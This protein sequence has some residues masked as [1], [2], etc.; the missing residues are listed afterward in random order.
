MN[1][2]GAATQRPWLLLLALVATL[3][4]PM[5]ASVFVSMPIDAPRSAVWRAVTDAR[6]LSR[7]QADTATGGLEQGNFVLGWPSLGAH[8]ALDVVRAVP[9]ESIVLRGGGATVEIALKDGAVELEHRGLGPNEDLEGLRAS[10]SVALG[11]LSHYLRHH[12]GSDRHVSWVARPMRTSAEVAHVFFT[13][14]RALASWLT[15]G[16]GGIGN[17]GEPVSFTSHWGARFAGTVLVRRPGRDV[18]LVLSSPEDSVLVLRTLPSPIS[19]RDR[20][21]AVVWSRWGAVPASPL[22]NQ[23][24]GAVARLKTVL[25]STSADERSV[26]PH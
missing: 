10:W 13:E 19:A 23:L 2:A 5:T 6:S 9:E 15:R 3:P 26:R 17:V 4:K 14:Q 8:L 22:P 25:E 18:A 20:L 12:E 11:L 16:D 7:W 21:V 24:S 1:Q